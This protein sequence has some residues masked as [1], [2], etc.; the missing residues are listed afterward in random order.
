MAENAIPAVRTGK[1]VTVHNARSVDE[2]A[3]PL[4]NTSPDVVTVTG[5]T[6]AR[7]E[8]RLTGTS[9]DLTPLMWDD[10]NDV[11]QQ[12]VKRTVST[13]GEVFYVCV[14][15]Y[16]HFYVKADGKAGSSP[17]VTVRVTPVNATI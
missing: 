11:W 15:G 16:D 9:W 17:T 8:V 2:P 10:D 12:G 13:S 14:A 1:R 3:N 6:Y 5:Y 4:S 7:V